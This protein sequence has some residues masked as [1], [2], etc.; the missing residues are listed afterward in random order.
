MSLLYGEASTVLSCEEKKKKIKFSILQLS[1]NCGLAYR[2]PSLACELTPI[3][4]RYQ[5]HRFMQHLYRAKPK[6]LGGVIV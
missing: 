2:G 1:R 3:R 4:R 5:H 6:N